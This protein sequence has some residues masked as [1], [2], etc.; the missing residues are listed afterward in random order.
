MGHIVLGQ[1]PDVLT[2]VL[3]SCVAVALH[4][5][6]AGIGALA[7][8]VLPDSSGRT[9]SPGKFAD[10]AV[11]AMLAQLA[12]AGVCPSELHARLVGG[13][14][15]FGYDTPLQVGPA[16][17]EAACQALAKAGIPITAQDVGGTKGR[18]VA[19]RCD[20]GELLV[21]ILGEVPRTL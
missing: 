8:I 7:H 17:A 19:L 3:G 12:S 21:E 13:G 18:R 4:C 11:P 14:C 1:G 2:A 20:T 10:T 6:R 15:M 5:R 16:N 9:G